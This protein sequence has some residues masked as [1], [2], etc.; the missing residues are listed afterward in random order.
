L[1]T[2]NVWQAALGTDYAISR[3]I[4]AFAAIDYSH[5]GFGKSAFESGGP[6]EPQQYEPNSVSD[7]A[8][9]NVGLAW[10]Y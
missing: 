6:I 8:K 7:L 3:R 9:V 4:H 10:S 2:R 1:G 5:F